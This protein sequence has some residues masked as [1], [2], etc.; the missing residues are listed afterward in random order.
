MDVKFKKI[1]ETREQQSISTTD[2]II[3]PNK[4]LK[5]IS[6]IEAHLN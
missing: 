5:V 2:V 6:R 4:Y 3:N 1:E